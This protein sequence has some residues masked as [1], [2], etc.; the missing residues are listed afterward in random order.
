MAQFILSLVFKTINGPLLS[1]K[2]E[3]RGKFIPYM[4]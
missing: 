4:F 2:W 3:G 1:A